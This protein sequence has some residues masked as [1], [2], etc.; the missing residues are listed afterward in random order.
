MQIKE[1]LKMK[2]KVLAR[3]AAS[4]IS[5]AMLGTAVFAA[6]PAISKDETSA[7]LSFLV[8]TDNADISINAD[9]NQIT[10]M[11]YMVDATINEVETT[12]EN[13]PEYGAAGAGEMI[14]LDQ[15][16]GAAGFGE[17][18]VDVTKL[19]EGK[20][21]A[22]KL[23]C[24]SGTVSKFL[25]ALSADQETI[26]FT[27]GDATEDGAVTTADVNAIKV[28]LK[29]GTHPKYTKINTTEDIVVSK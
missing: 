6:D 29:K 4:A 21:I 17:V 1:V 23:G 13:M 2:N 7:T 12:V 26:A 14:A 19:A 10:M 5:V 24:T 16:G 15:V 18:P 28:F 20:K 8:G 11:A 22:V 25:I 27:F 9:E 3:I